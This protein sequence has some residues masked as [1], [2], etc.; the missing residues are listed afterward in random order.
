V[1]FIEAALYCL[2][3][4]YS[5]EDVNFITDDEMTAYGPQSNPKYGHA[6]CGLWFALQ[7]RIEVLIKHGMYTQDVIDSITPYLERSQF[8]KIRGHKTCV[9]NQRCDYIAKIAA[10]VRAFGGA[11]IMSF[12]QWAKLGLSVWKNGTNIQFHPPFVTTCDLVTN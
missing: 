3:H 12:E 10:R 2:S 7:Q 4:G 9:M 5:P 1:A 6:Q 8:H 11:K